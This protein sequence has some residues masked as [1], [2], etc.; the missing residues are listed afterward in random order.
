MPGNREIRRKRGPMAGIPGEK[1]VGFDSLPGGV[2]MTVCVWDL[3]S[4]DF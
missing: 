3:Y 1:S 2:G 4:T